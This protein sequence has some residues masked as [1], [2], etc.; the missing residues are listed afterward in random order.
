MRSRN[1]TI[2]KM[3]NFSPSDVKNQPDNYDDEDHLS[4]NSSHSGSQND[5][6]SSYTKSY[7]SGSNADEND[8]D[9]IRAHLTKQ[10]TKHVDR[11]RTSVLIA[12]LLSGIG[13]TLGIY[14]IAKRAEQDSF[15]AQYDGAADKIIESF[16]SIATKVG[17]INS[18]GISLTS[19]GYN[20]TSNQT[21]WP[22]VTLPSFQQRAASARL[23][24]SALFISTAPIVSEDNRDK[25]EEYSVG[26]SKHW[27]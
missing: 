2:F 11:L 23:L 22:F 16:E 12:I 18:I 15:N 3:R 20:E 14:F 27:M 26:D 21:S 25:W 6:Q 10:E 5:L 24:S 8:S 1:F 4:V 13:I 19:Q 17:S 7:A 9:N